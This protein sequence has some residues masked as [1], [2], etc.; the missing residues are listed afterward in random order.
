MNSHGQLDLFHYG[1]ASV[2]VRGALLDHRIEYVLNP[3]M[4]D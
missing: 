1:K 3:G 2:R 4:L